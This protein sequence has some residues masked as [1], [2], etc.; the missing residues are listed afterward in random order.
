MV[1][2]SLSLGWAATYNPETV[3]LKVKTGEGVYTE[4]PV[5]KAARTQA[6]LSQSDSFGE[7]A[8]AFDLWRAKLP[9]VEGVLIRPVPDYEIRDA[10]GITYGIK[11]VEVCDL[12]ERF[13]CACIIL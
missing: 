10:A 3:T 2:T 6:T 1:T 7:T 9:L 11:S 12:G 8:L 13:H 4:Y 5:E